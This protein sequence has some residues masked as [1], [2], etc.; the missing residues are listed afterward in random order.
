MLTSRTLIYAGFDIPEEE[1]EADGLPRVKVG[2][3]AFSRIVPNETVECSDKKLDRT[4]HRMLAH[5]FSTAVRIGRKK[6]P[7]CGGWSVNQSIWRLLSLS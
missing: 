7:R 6:K 1:F 4:D 2:N 5:T 3:H